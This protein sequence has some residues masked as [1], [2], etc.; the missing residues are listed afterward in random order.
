MIAGV[1]DSAQ[2]LGADFYAHHVVEIVEVLISHG[3]TPVV[4]EVPEYGIEA[5]REERSGLSLLKDVVLTA[6]YDQGEID[7]IG[8]YREALRDALGAAGLLEMIELVD[9][10]PVARDY[11]EAIDLYQDPAHLNDEGREILTA[12][13]AS[14]IRARLERDGLIDS[15]QARL[16]PR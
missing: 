8:K 11:H 4:V 9:F 10:E 7:V 1:N 14:A 13:L 3:I 5:V 2:H 16:A 6:L 12:H 15:E